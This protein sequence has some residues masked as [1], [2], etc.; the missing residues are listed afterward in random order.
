[1]TCGW[2]HRTRLMVTSRRRCGDICS[3]IVRLRCLKASDRPDVLVLGGE[4]VDL[5]GLLGRLAPDAIALV[6]RVFQQAQEQLN[7]DGAYAAAA[8]RSPDELVTA[9]LGKQLARMIADGDSSSMGNSTAGIRA[10]ELSHYEELVD[11]NSALAAALGAC[12]CWGQ[13]AN[14]PF[15]SGVGTPGW[16]IPDE[17][18]FKSYVRPALSAVANPS[19]SSTVQ[20]RQAQSHQK[21]GEDV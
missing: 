2:G 20:E 8:V 12:D 11:R 18:L 17:Q 7:R 14:C 3:P 5:G 1:M 16:I 13:L 9:A 10:D 15:C 4:A 19:A 21:E 6:D